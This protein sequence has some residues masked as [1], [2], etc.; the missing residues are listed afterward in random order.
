[1]IKLCNPLFSY[2][3]FYTLN[4]YNS[5]DIYVPSIKFIYSFLF[6]LDQYT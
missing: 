4:P 1:M 5:K 2:Y 6:K 3:Y